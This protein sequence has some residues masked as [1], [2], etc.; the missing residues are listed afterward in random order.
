MRGFTSINDLGPSLSVTFCYIKDETDDQNDS[1][2]PHRASR[3]TMNE[4]N[5]ISRNL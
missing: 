4:S 3:T 1:D 2:E 5:K